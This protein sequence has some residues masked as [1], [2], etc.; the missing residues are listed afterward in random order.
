M[1]KAHKKGIKALGI[2]L[3]VSLLLTGC[4]S[5]SGNVTVKVSSNDFFTIGKSS[6]PVSIVKL[7]A[8]ENLKENSK[9]YGIDLTEHPNLK[10][11]KRYEQYIENVT[12]DELTA[13]YAKALLAKSL[14]INLTE[15]EEELME[16]AAEDYYGSLDEE[17]VKLTDV[18]V[19]ELEQYYKNYA[20]SEKLYNKLIANVNYEVSDDE[21]RVMHVEKLVTSDKNRALSALK[22]IKDGDSF[23]SVA[24]NYSEDGEVSI[25]LTRG[26]LPEEIEDIVFSLNDN[27]VTEVLESDGKYYVFCCI[28]KYD[29]ELT[30][31]HK[32]DIREQREYNAFTLVYDKF[33][34]STPSAINEEEYAKFDVSNLYEFKTTALLE[35]YKKYNK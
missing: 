31:A 9:S 20:L 12:I 3:F 4:G 1:L 19:N 35:I 23:A 2:A 18:T 22:E 15:D 24:A 29:E 30:E 34:E 14:D 26:V 6:C 10:V 17:E 16:W 8:A 13:V 28:D 25:T 27:G 5:N 11:K 32:K 7:V 21:A 33:L